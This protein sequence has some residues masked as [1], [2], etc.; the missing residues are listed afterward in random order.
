MKRYILIIL[1]PLMMV[2]TSIQADTNTSFS[3]PRTSTVTLQDVNTK[4]SYDI[5]V[6]L[7]KKYDASKRYPVVYMTDAPYTFPIVTGA[8]RYPMNFN[9]TDAVIFV[10]I[11]WQRGHSGGLSRQRDYTPTKSSPGFKDPSGEADKHMAFIRDTVIQYVESHYSADVSRRT[12]VGNSF[13][14][15][16][17][18]YILLHEPAM[19]TNYI[20]GSPSFWWDNNYLLDRLSDTQF[21]KGLQ[22]NVFISVGSLEVPSQKHTSKDMVGVATAFHQG[23]LSKNI[24]GLQSELRLIGHANHYTAF[25]TTAIQ[26]LWWFFSVDGK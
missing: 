13:G 3:L 20:L 1:M 2:T 9:R 21:P 6:Q 10:G 8:A 4:R 7:P 17:G 24:V 12:Y 11:A 25:P 23:L 26:G 15:L 19:F 16:F 14:G 5:Y 18:G 22:A